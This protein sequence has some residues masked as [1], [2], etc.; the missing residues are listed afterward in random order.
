MLRTNVQTFFGVL[1]FFSI[2]LFIINQYYYFSSSIESQKNYFKSEK[3]Q[4]EVDHKNELSK[5]KD[6][7]FKQINELKQ[8]NLKIKTE[9]NQISQK[10]QEMVKI[11]NLQV[12]RGNSKGLVSKNEMNK[13]E[14][15]PNEHLKIRIIGQ[16]IF[17]KSGFQ[18][19]EKSFK[20]IS[21]NFESIGLKFEYHAFSPKLRGSQTK[22]N[23]NHP[24]FHFNELNS[25]HLTLKQKMSKIQFP[26][27]SRQTRI[28]SQGIN[29]IQT[30]STFYS[31]CQKDEIFLYMEDDFLICE[32]SAIQIASI[33]F[34][35]LKHRS[36]FK[37]LRIGFGFSGILM[38]CPLIP[39][40]VDETLKQSIEKNY[41]IDYSI[42]NWWSTHTWKNKNYGLIVF[43]YNLFDH[44]GFNSS[45]GNDEDHSH[46]PTCYS[47]NYH[48]YNF[49]MEKFNTQSCDKYMFSPCDDVSLQIDV[50][51]LNRDTIKVR[52]ILKLED[53]QL[54]MKKLNIKVYSPSFD[55]E[56]GVSCKMACESHQ[57]SCHS[58]LYP[59]VNTCEEMQSFYGCAPCGTMLKGVNRLDPPMKDEEGNCI[60][61]DFPEF[62]CEHKSFRKIKKICACL[63]K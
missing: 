20:S 32:Y 43:R 33:Y 45:I 26:I 55:T 34:W 18:Y 62:H 49:H 60:H 48:D 12:S 56:K 1:L 53:R 58:N 39:E 40:M 54:M 8:Q 19:L 63:G 57:S 35:A 27:N 3:Q 46:Q 61:V 4:N 52:S 17:R 10:T 51:T 6:F 9:K 38:K 41:P 23:I 13:N 22:P 31:I 15:N 2:L 25:S 42:A 47:G 44:I 21:E 36:A 16:T 7:Y 11:F 50:N 37:A 59:L 30:L 29:F 14:L 24:N 28:L 5:Q